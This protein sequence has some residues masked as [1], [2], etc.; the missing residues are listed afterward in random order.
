M[1]IQDDITFTDNACEL[2]YAGTEVA[3]GAEGEQL[4]IWIGQTVEAMG[5]TFTE[6]Q[7]ARLLDYL[8][9]RKAGRASR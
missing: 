6:E 2:G 1:D 9:G 8:Q 7:E 5:W 3:I 4:H